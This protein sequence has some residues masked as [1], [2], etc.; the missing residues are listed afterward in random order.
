ME[1]ALLGFAI[2]AVLIAVG[3]VLAS[4]SPGMAAR[5]QRGCIPL[6]YTVLNPCLMVVLVSQVDVRELLGLYT[7][8]ALVTALT[9]A[10]CFTAF[11]VV[12]RRRAPDVAVGAMSA[13][14]VNAGNIGV[15]IAL[16]VTGSTTPVVSVLLAQLLVLAPV[17][18]CIFGVVA[19]RIR[20]P[21]G[22]RAAG[23]TRSLALTLI[24]SAL[25]PVTL[26]ALTGGL[27]AWFEITPAPVLWE[28]VRM[29]GESAIPLMLLLF[30]IA[31]RQERPY[32]VRDRTLDTVVATVCKVAVM[33][34]AAWVIT[35]PVLGLSSAAV[36][37]VV[38]MASLP[39]A[40]NVYLF[41]RQ[42][43]IPV[44]VAKDVSFT[45][46]ILAF[47]VTMLALALLGTT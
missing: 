9:S 2:V 34:L 36:I 11:A 18:L 10:L 16:Y 15:P 28:P 7:P 14:Y 35:G 33:P 22:A 3:A 43:R 24:R 1:G 19:R 46:S 21:E 25:N 39:T 38:A 29:L 17:F 13:C 30:G 45:S 37:G 41:G 47:P 20:T 42:H 12:A 31:L 40:Q 4:I 8:I 23:R 27:L 44:T 6:V 26:G 5:V 32:T